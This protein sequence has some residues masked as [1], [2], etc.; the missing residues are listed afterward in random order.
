[1]AI[2]GEANGWLYEMYPL[3]TPAAAL[4]TIG[5]FKGLYDRKRPAGAMPAWRDFNLDDFTDWHGWISVEDVI[6]GTPYDAKVRLW[7]TMLVRFFGVEITGKRVSDHVGALYSK[8]DLV[9]CKEIANG[10]GFRVCNGPLQW[11]NPDYANASPYYSFVQLP[12]ADDGQ[13]VDKLISLTVPD[14][15]SALLAEPQLVSHP[16]A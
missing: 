3:D 4:S 11:Q 6:P 14:Q 13:T 9:M 15:I 1:M 16:S 2:W 7:G 12:L 10:R 5:A 8:E